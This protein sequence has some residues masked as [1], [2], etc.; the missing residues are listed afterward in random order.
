MKIGPSNN[1]APYRPLAIRG[2]SYDFDLGGICQA[3]ED[4]VEALSDSVVLPERHLEDANMSAAF[5]VAASLIGTPA[6]VALAGQVM[7]ELCD[8]QCLE[9]VDQDLNNL[10]GI[11]PETQLAGTDVLVGFGNPEE[12]GQAKFTTITLDPQ[13]ESFL[14]APLGDFIAGHE[15]GH[16]RDKDMLRRLGQAV[17]QGCVT[18]PLAAQIADAGNSLARQDE[19]EAD[20]AGIDYAL[21]QGHSKEEI[22]KATDYLMTLLN[23]EGDATHPSTQA[24]SAAIRK[25]LEE[26]QP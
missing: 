19:F 25:H 20:L 14:G 16:L 11:K 12:L 26:T 15:L 7:V 18:E 22:L 4:K 6:A 3:Y 24:R 17:L 9:E 21:S 23:P 2:D 10:E 5:Q 13:L 1:Q 8:D